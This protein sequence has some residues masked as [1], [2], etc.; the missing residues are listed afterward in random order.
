MIYAR[1][2]LAAVGL[3]LATAVVALPSAVPPAAHAQAFPSQPIRI[4]VTHAAGGLPDTIARL[5]G[6][7]LQE[8]VGQSVVIENRAGANGAI[9]VQAMLGAPA[10]GY[11]LIVTDGAIITS[12]PVLVTKLGYNVQD[13]LTIAGLGRAPLFLAVH[14]KVP[15]STFAEFIAYVK[16]R[17]GQV[18]FGS[19]GV[20]SLHHLSMEAMAASLGLKMVHV[21]FKGT[22]ESVPALLGGHIEALKSAYPSLSGAADGKQVKLLAANSEQRSQQAPQLPA[23]AE[24][25]PGFDYAPIVGLYGRVGTPAEVT[26]KLVA[27]ALA[28]QKESE[29]VKQLAVVGVEPMPMDTEQFGKALAGEARRIAQAVE[30]SGIKPR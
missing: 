30:L 1:A 29:Y 14:P 6:R 2:R 27:E 3:A 12:N 19:S 15:A 18:N 11:T 25:I 8:R 22:G 17:P 20:G 13:V 23:I 28:I 4:I 24:T 5:F 21:P 7:R 16:E 26:A 10:D 9:A